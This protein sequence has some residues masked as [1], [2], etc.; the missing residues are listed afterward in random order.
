MNERLIGEYF[1]IFILD[2]NCVL[3]RKQQP[4]GIYS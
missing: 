1:G 2:A 3:G 4:F